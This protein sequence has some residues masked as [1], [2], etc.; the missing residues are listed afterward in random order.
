MGQGAGGVDRVG[1]YSQF[2]LVGTRIDG[3]CIVDVSCTI[4]GCCAVD[5]ESAGNSL[6]AADRDVACGI[7]GTGGDIAG[8]IDSFGRG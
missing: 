8:V 1:R 2:C 7:Q 4:K 3:Q 6:V 5:T